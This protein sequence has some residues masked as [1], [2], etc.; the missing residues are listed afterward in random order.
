MCAAP[1][2]PDIAAN[3]KSIVFRYLGWAGLI[4]LFLVPSLISNW[5]LVERIPGVRQIE[6]W[7][8]EESI[9]SADPGRF[10]IAVAHFHGDQN[11]YPNEQLLL[12]A[13]KEIGGIQV[14]RFDRTISVQATQGERGEEAGH[15]LAQ[16]YLRASNADVLIWG[17][18]L[19]GPNS[20][21][22]K[23]YWTTNG[24]YPA[25]WGRYQ[26]TGNLSLPQS[27]WDDVKSIVIFLAL[28]QHDR[29]HDLYKRGVFAASQFSM[30]ANRIKGLLETKGQIWGAEFVLKAQLMVGDLLSAFGEQTGDKASIEQALQIYLKALPGIFQHQNPLLWAFVN[31]NIGVS[32]MYLGSVEGDIQKLEEA[33]KFFREALQVR[34]PKQFP[35]DWARTQSNI[36]GTL[37]FLGIQEQNP[38]RVKEAV[39]TLRTALEKQ[40]DKRAPMDWALT[41]IRLAKTLWFLG[42]EEHDGAQ[43]REAETAVKQ[44]LTKLSPATTPLVWVDAQ[45]TMGNILRGLSTGQTGTKELDEAIAAFEIIQK[46]V[47]RDRDPWKWAVL[48]Y[49]YANVLVDYA[50]KETGIAGT[51]KLKEGIQK[52]YESLEIR[53]RTADPFGWALTQRTIGAALSVLGLREVG[54]KRLEAAVLAY[55]RA[56]EIISPNRM[57]VDWAGIHY[58]LATTL[59]EMGQRKKNAQLLCEGLKH[60]YQAWYGFSDANAASQALAAQRNVA[61]MIQSFEKQFSKREVSNCLGRVSPKP[62]LSS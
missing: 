34:N 31:N 7:L 24:N 22:F 62:K 3:F 10:S 53:T 36:G 12:E 51:I 32:Y 13:L 61:A 52:L 42:I 4:L 45:W 9:P 44:A 26:P 15:I 46:H 19:S 54:T 43:L 23:L 57:P 55:N 59:F 38:K 30:Y 27:F 6:K 29:Q 35:L 40:D 17:T 21:V 2:P 41:Q 25:K 47:R 39:Q 58:G 49:D 37:R 20:T 60:S 56:L 5:G 1:T 33:L 18:I 11:G 8:R 48:Q 16:K 50:E 14:L 28:A